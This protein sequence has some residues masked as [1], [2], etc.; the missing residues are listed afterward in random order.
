MD[1]R[2][3]HCVASNYEWLRFKTCRCRHTVGSRWL[4]RACRMV[5]MILWLKEDGQF[6]FC[7]LSKLTAHPLEETHQSEGGRGKE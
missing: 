5:L 3:G 7:L 2:T 6:V 4:S 1:C